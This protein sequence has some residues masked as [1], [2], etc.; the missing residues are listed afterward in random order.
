MVSESTLL[1]VPRYWQC[2]S[3]GVHRRVLE[4]SWS[5]REPGLSREREQIANQGLGLG[6]LLY[7]SL[8]QKSKRLKILKP[9]LSG[10][11][12]VNFSK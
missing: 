4:A 6:S 10:N 8:A 2:A 12:K 5:G 11:R 3:W 1:V 7:H 9:G